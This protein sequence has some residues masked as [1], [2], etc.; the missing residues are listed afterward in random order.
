MRCLLPRQTQLHSKGCTRTCGKGNLT[1]PSIPILTLTPPFLLLP[2]A[3]SSPFHTSY[4]SK[5][6]YLSPPTL[7]RNIPEGYKKSPEL[8]TLLSAGWGRSWPADRRDG[9]AHTPVS[10]QKPSWSPPTCGHWSLFVVQT[11]AFF[12]MIV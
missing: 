12:Q 11:S 5:T 7:Y 2:P 6:F 8:H 1:F 10:H 4:L 9:H 3:I